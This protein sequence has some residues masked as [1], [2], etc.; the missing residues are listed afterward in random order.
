MEKDVNNNTYKVCF[1]LVSN[2]DDNR[3]KARITCEFI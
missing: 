2:V 1:L 3:L